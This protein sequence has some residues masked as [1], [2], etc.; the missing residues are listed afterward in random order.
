ME[1]SMLKRFWKISFFFLLSL[2]LFISFQNFAIPTAVSSVT[3]TEFIGKNYVGYQAWFNVPADGAKRG[4]THW[5]RTN[6]PRID[7]MTIDMWP[8]TR[9]YPLATLQETSF[10]LG[11]GTRAKVFS[12][13]PQAVI[14]KHFEWMQQYSV[15]GAFLQWFVTEPTA[16]RL[17]IAKRVRNSAQKY[18]RQFSVMFDISGTT[19]MANCDTGAELVNCIKDRWIQLVNSGVVSSSNYIKHKNKPLVSIWGLGFTHNSNLSYD[20]AINLIY[21]FKTSAPIQYQASVMG[22]VDFAW[23][24]LGSDAVI[25][26]QNWLNVY[27][28][29]DIISPWSVGRFQN[30]SQAA[31]EIKSRVS[32]DINLI[33]SRNQKYLP[34]IFPGFSWS[35]LQRDPNIFNFIPRN[36]GQFMWTQARELAQLGIKSTY[37]AMFDEVD[38]GTA[39]FKIAPNSSLKPREFQTVSIDQD[40]LAGVSGSDW[41]LK[42]SQTI[43]RALKS[44]NLSGF[45]SEQLPIL[46]TKPTGSYTYLRGTIF[47]GERIGNSSIYLAFQNDGN[48]VV[49]RGVD[50]V[51]LWASGTLFGNCTGNCRTVFQDDGNLVIY[52]SNNLVKFASGVNSPGAKLIISTSNPSIKTVSSTGVVLWEGA[53]LPVPAIDY[54]SFSSGITFNVNS[55]K[56]N[57]Y[58]R[59]IFQADGNL[60]VYRVSDN[61]ALW[62][63]DTIINN[64]S[65]NCRTVF[66]SD[67]NLVI[68]DSNNLVKF[69][70]NTFGSGFTLRVSPTSPIISIRNSSGTVVWS[71]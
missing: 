54:L 21:W 71:R 4:W 42:V 32:A 31:A 9:E 50:N 64:C 6:P 24:D 36:G 43:S 12:S 56:A 60:V 68:Y 49:Y 8:D 52:D 3:P 57:N 16:Y 40:R 65:G 14:D 19:N 34:V 17:E 35:H 46:I 27:A 62:A 38:E 48:L 66:Q 28:K 63:S 18:G 37:T 23:R 67:G 10:L 58:I 1:D 41:Y 29:L 30:E 33:R 47:P 53:S 70:S 55:L 20:E 61:S 45:A 11:N 69:S 26:D 13:F 5:S 59:F 22:G 39:I 44:S 51:P 25:K 7:S 15:D 2:F